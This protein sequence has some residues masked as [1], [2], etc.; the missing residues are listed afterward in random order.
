MSEPRSARG[1]A[2]R[3]VL[4]DAA[5][6]VFER[7]GFLD[8]RI[9]DIA[10]EAGVATGSFYTYF[11]DKNDA[12]AAVMEQVNEEMLHP[13]L[14]EKF[15][16]PVETIE[17][18]NRAYLKSYRRNARLMGLMEQVASI[19]DDFRQVRRRRAKD[20]ARRNARLIARLQGEGLA[21]PELDPHLTSLALSSMVSRVAYSVYVLGDEIPLEKLV[22]TLTR[23]WAGALR[24]PPRA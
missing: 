21:D 12:F 10:A 15:D 13:L 16:N 9:V 7:D 23:L 11:K 24:I 6:A 1:Q 22:K 5:R 8:A 4:I 2:T 20:F 18:A 19:D 14:S 3:G 17:Q